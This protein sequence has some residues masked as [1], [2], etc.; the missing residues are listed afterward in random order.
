MSIQK[1][2]RRVSPSKDLV[3]HAPKDPQNIY[4]EQLLK[5]FCAEIGQATYLG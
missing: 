4:Q 1:V 5:L 2:Q 3:F